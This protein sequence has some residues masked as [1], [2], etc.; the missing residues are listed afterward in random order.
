M[1]WNCRVGFW[2]CC[3]STAEPL[4]LKLLFP[5][6][7]FPQELQ[8]LS[9]RESKSSLAGSG[10]NPSTLVRLGTSQ[11]VANRL[12][13]LLQPKK[14][15]QVWRCL[16]ASQLLWGLPHRQLAVP[17]FWWCAYVSMHW[18]RPLLQSAFSSVQKEQ[19]FQ[20][21]FSWFLAYNSISKIESCLLRNVLDIMVL[22]LHPGMGVTVSAVFPGCSLLPLA[23]PQSYADTLETGGLVRWRGRELAPRGR[24]CRECVPD[25][26]ERR[27]ERNHM[28][29]PRRHDRSLYVGY[30]VLR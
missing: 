29:V 1:V 21:Q 19:Q 22:H 4:V 24:S 20:F 10:F 2:P 17:A 23:F 16:P 28:V 14:N 5:S 25:A 26:A 15:R 12:C 11:S 3:G 7:A 30:R 27:R 9:T 8:W 6:V 13:R 18:L